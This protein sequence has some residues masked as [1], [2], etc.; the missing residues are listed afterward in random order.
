MGNQSSTKVSA[1]IEYTADKQWYMVNNGKY[2]CPY[3]GKVH[4]ELTV[5]CG[6]LHST[7]IEMP[8]NW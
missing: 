6:E 5:C 1:N 8:S 2:Q 3:C 7:R 4:A